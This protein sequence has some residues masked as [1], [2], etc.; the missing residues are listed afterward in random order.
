MYF[1]VAL[2]FLLSFSFVCAHDIEELFDLILNEDLNEL[3]SHAE[4]EVLKNRDLESKAYYLNPYIYYAEARHQLNTCPVYRKNEVQHM[5]EVITS[6]IVSRHNLET[7]DVA[8]LRKYPLQNNSITRQLR[9]QCIDPRSTNCT[10]IRYPKIDGSCNNPE[11]PNEGR[12][13]S[14]FDRLLQPH[15]ADGVSEP[16]TGTFGPLPNPRI[17]SIEIHRTASSGSLSWKWSALLPSFGQFIDHDIEFGTQPTTENNEAIGCCAG[18]PLHPSCLPITIPPND[19][20]FPNITCMNFVRDAVCQACSLGWRE[21]MNSLTPAI[22]C[23]QVYGTSLDQSQRLRDMNGSG[24]KLASRMTSVGELPPAI[25]NS[26]AQCSPQF[27]CF[28]TGDFRSNQNLPLA[29]LHVTFLRMH[30]VVVQK[31]KELNPSWG[32]ETLFQEGRLIIMYIFQRIVFNEYLPIIIGQELMDKS[33]LNE[34]NTI[35]T[36]DVIL[37]IWN[38]FAATAFRLHSTVPKD[39][40]LVSKE[41]NF[42]SVRLQDTFFNMT[43]IYLRGIEDVIR[44]AT[45]QPQENFDNL[46]DRSLTQ[47]LYRRNISSLGLD[48]S[49]INIQRGRDHGIPPYTRFVSWFHGFNIRTFPDFVSYGLMNSENAEKLSRI[50]RHVDDVD[51]FTGLN[52]E[53]FLT[54]AVVGP[55]SAILISQQFLRFKLGFRFFYTHNGALT[56][57]QRRIIDR[58]K[59]SHIFCYANKMPEITVDVFYKNSP[60]INCND[61]PPLDLS[62]WKE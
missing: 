36:G 11:R 53:K 15:Y 12:T 7:F 29:S 39:I 56:S 44:G 34:Q 26:T 4:R 6:D 23:S 31:L 24:S 47:F 43:Q 48:L 13:F 60:I 14:C 57:A 52:C 55:T 8:L 22:D 49:S 25:V 1:N 32:E 54:G 10:D 46:L 2:R 3:V 41:G 21:Q 17:I 51:F 5:L 35:Y 30:N 37:N 40:F 38:S 33:G 59:L 27:P 28:L 16:R 45:R 42:N 50:Y 18:S 62:P 20:D 58:I 9:Q 19:P 61:I